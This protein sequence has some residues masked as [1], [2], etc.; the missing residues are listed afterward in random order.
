MFKSQSGAE[1][2]IFL[3]IKSITYWKDFSS[4]SLLIWALWVFRFLCSKKKNNTSTIMILLS[5]KL[6]LHS[7]QFVFT[8]VDTTDGEGIIALPELTC[9]DFQGENA[10]M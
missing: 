7:D 5:C 3:S 9:P 6:R 10:L 8:P 2:V 4:P 1:R